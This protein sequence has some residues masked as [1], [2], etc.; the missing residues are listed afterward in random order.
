[1]GASV[2]IVAI[3]VVII[4][5]FSLGGGPNSSTTTPTT[6]PAKQ[7]LGLKDK[8]PKGSP[9]MPLA[10]GP[11]PTTLATKDLKVGTGAVIP[12]NAKVLINYVG[13]ACS[14]GK[15]FDSSYKTGSPFEAD[16]SPTGSLI[17]GW[18]QGI[19][20]MKIGG[21][22]LLS[23]PSAL[24]YASAGQGDIGPDEPLYFIVAPVKLG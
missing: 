22:R 9:A 1:M 11:A 16:L 8:L 10:A 6:L 20:G 17:V 12:K 15:I 7:C 5:G 2:L 19:P 13:V 14:N 18:Q 21:V 23:I 24:A 3:V 4:L